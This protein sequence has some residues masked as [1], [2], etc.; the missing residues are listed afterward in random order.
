MR[1]WHKIQKFNSAI[2]HNCKN[3]YR[4]FPILSQ[5]L[6]LILFFLHCRMF[7]CL[8][9]NFKFFS[10]LIKILYQEEVSLGNFKSYKSYEANLQ[11]DIWTYNFLLFLHSF[12]LFHALWKN[13]KIIYRKNLTCTFWQYKTICTNIF[14]KSRHVTGTEP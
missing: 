6:N 12:S 7:K 14:N 10:E 13:S 8:N 4:K 2:L 11:G 5:L 9:L 3:K 1:F